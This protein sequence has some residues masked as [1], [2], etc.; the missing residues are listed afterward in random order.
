MKKQKKLHPADLA[1]LCSEYAMILRS[2]IPLYDGIAILSQSAQDT[3][4]RPLLEHIQ[5][6]MQQGASLYEALADTGQF[7]AY[8]LEMIRL[9]EQTGTLETILE[10]LSAYYER[11]AL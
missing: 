9:A 11:I 2:G 4:S 1:V 10:D 5:A 3:P 6:D 8:M 7:P